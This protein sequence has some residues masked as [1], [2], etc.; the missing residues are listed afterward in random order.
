MNVLVRCY[1]FYNDAE[2]KHIS[3]YNVLGV[4]Y[5][6]WSLRF[7]LYSFLTSLFSVPSYCISILVFSLLSQH[8]LLSCVLLSSPLFP[9]RSGG[10]VDLE[11]FLQGSV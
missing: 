3:G 7:P 4:Y 5:R 2:I 1:M 9:P 8:A 11:A 6:P 10:E